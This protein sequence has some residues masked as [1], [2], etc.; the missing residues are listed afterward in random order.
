MVPQATTREMQS[1]ERRSLHALCVF[2]LEVR[3]FT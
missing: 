1:K 3:L 2:D